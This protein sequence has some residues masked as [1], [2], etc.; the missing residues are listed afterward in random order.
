MYFGKLYSDLSRGQPK[1]WFK[2]IAAN[3]LSSGS[4]AKYTYILYIDISFAQMY[5]MLI[6]STGNVSPN[7]W[8]FT[9]ESQVA[10]C[11]CIVPPKFQGASEWLWTPGVGFCVCHVVWRA[12]GRCYHRRFFFWKEANS[13]VDYCEYHCVVRWTT[14]LSTMV[15]LPIQYF[16]P[17]GYF[18]QSPRFATIIVV[19]G[20][21]SNATPGNKAFLRAYWGIMVVK[22]PLIR[23]YFFGIGGAPLDS[24]S[25]PPNKNGTEQHLGGRVCF[26]LFFFDRKIII[27]GCLGKTIGSLGKK[28]KD[29]FRGKT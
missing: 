21:P 22:N 5:G 13:G 3:V 18:P 27:L 24:H 2:G 6:V 4:G 9:C 20:Y 8:L 16:L 17:K 11:T 25:H 23:P 26:C 7:T 12:D 1:L 29:H 14:M 10:Y 19:Q 28:T 15:L